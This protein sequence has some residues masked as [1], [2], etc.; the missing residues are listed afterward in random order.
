MASRAK[1]ER[2]EA[3]KKNVEIHRLDLKSQKQKI[4]DCRKVELYKTI[5]E[6]INVKLSNKEISPEAKK[7]LEKEKMIYETKVQNNSEDN[8]TLWKMKFEF[9][10]L[11][12]E[13]GRCKIRRRC[14]VPTCS[15]PRSIFKKFGICRL[16]IRDLAGKR[17]LA[18]KI[19]KESW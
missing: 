18:G 15:R 16:H 1:H 10:N 3:R 7:I 5:I 4:V 17:L 14:S 6:N 2:N 11:G 9:S 19:R 13:V 8:A 12:K